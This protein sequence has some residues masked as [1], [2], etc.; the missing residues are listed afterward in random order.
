MGTQP[1]VQSPLQKY[2]FGTS[3]QKILKAGI[4]YFYI[5]QFL[6]VSYFHYQTNEITA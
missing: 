1:T 3:A 5:A 4:K 6:N 2:F